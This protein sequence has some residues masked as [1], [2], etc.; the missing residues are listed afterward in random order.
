MKS[1]KR[2]T[3]KNSTIFSVNLSE[4][5]DAYVRAICFR[6]KCSRSEYFHRLVEKDMKECDAETR[7]F[8]SILGVELG[9]Q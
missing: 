3:M 7:K 6:R 9:P 8:L 1:L 5:M 4:E 2:C